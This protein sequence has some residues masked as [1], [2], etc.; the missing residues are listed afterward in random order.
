MLLNRVEKAIINNPVR[1]WMLRGAID[2]LY[3]MAGRPRITR[4]LEIG[5]G[6]GAGL[7]AITHTV[8][9][10]VLDAFDLD[11][12]QV[13]RAQA[14]LGGRGRAIG[15]LWVGDAEHIEAT[16][17]TYDAVFELTIL[18]H[19]PDWR[20]ALTEIARVLKPGG[21]FL[22]E[23]LSREFFQETG[24]LSWALRRYTDHPWAQMLDWPSF[25]RGLA[26]AG[27]KMI[28]HQPQLVRGWH[29]GVAIR[30]Q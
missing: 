18:H 5:C 11:P 23:E 14:Q 3:Q 21:Y 28:Q 24:P 9:P 15:R 22:F 8:H 4:A 16:S 13:Q 10:E 19:V 6:E 29:R 7:P 12:A 27:L 25:T 20:R 26:D 30:A 1:G 17:E 2:N